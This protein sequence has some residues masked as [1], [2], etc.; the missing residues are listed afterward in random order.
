MMYKIMTRKPS[1]REYAEFEK[2]QWIVRTDGYYYVAA[3]P[4]RFLTDDSQCLRLKPIV[5]DYQ[6]H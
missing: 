1:K 5:Y 4:E 3:P 6:P 2:R